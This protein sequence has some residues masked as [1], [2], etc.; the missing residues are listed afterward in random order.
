MESV[1]R[2]TN[3]IAMKKQRDHLRY[4]D[5]TKI[6]SYD[7]MRK[8]TTRNPMRPKQ[9]I[10]LAFNKIEPEVLA[11]QLTFLEWKTLRRINFND[12]KA[13]AD[14]GIIHDNPPMERSIHLFNGL[15]Q[16]IQSMILSKTTPKQR[17][18]IIHKFICVARHLRQLQNFNSLMAVIGGICHSAIARLS[19]T[20]LHLSLEDQKVW[21]FFK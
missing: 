18:D 4:V 17:A 14:K 2:F 6:E 21:I 5:I 11:A 16:W 1:K 3:L 12:Y 8:L 20:N 9:K 19:K 7:W 13:Y 10:T 15:S